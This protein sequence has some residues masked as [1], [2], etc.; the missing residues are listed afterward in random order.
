MSFY[1][2]KGKPFFI[3]RT[4]HTWTFAEGM[5]AEGITK[6]NIMEKRYYLINDKPVKYLEKKYS[7]LSNEKKPNTGKLV[8]KESSPGTLPLEI[9]NLKS[10]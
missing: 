5:A 3:F 1:L 4:D 7:Y 2:D 8:A 10:S 6:E 9:A